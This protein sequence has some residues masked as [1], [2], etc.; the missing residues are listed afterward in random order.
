MKPSINSFDNVR[1]IHLGINNQM[2]R[3]KRDFCEF[4]NQTIRL[5]IKKSYQKYELDKRVN[6]FQIVV[7]FKISF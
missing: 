6:S 3:Y 4:L 1:K 2:M 7:L 5:F